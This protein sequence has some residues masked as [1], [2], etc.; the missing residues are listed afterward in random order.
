M[1]SL[2]VCPPPIHDEYTALVGYAFPE[3]LFNI[4]NEINKS[5]NNKE[6]YFWDNILKVL[7]SWENNVC[8]YHKV[9]QLYA[10]IHI[11]VGGND[12]LWHDRQIH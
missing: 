2:N 12:F 7:L 3:L 11:K 8:F 5:I 10:E 1:C 4:M 6:N 9:T